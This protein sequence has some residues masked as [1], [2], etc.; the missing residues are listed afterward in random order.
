MIFSDL[1][2]KVPSQQNLVTNKSP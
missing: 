1:E 2:T